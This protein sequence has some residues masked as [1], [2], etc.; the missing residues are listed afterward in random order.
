MSQTASIMTPA[1]TVSPKS[2]LSKEEAKAKREQEALEKEEKKK[3]REEEKAK[4]EE[5]KAKKEEEKKKRDEEKAKKDEERRKALEEKNKKKEEER[6]KKEED[7]KKKDEEK[8][9]KEEEKVKKEEEKKRKEEMEEEERARERARLEKNKKMWATSFGVTVEARPVPVQQPADDLMFKPYE[10]PQGAVAAPRL[11]LDSPR[12]NEQAFDQ[13]VSSSSVQIDSVLLPELRAKKRRRVHK[14]PSS[15]P[16]IPSSSSSSFHVVDLASLS[17]M[18]YL[19]F[20]ENHRPAYFGT[21]SKKSSVVRPRRPCAKD[22]SLFDYDYD[23][24]AEWEEE[25][26]G[27]SLSGSEGEEGEDAE[28]DDEEEGEKFLVP[29]GYL[30]ADEGMDSDREDR[31]LFF[32]DE[33]ASTA[34]G[35]SSSS[36]SSGK[37]RINTD[38]LADRD[39]VLKRE[40]NERP[41]VSIGVLWDPSTL[42]AS[43]LALVLPLYMQALVPVPIDPKQ[44]PVLPACED[45]PQGDA[46]PAINKKP[47]PDAVFLDIVRFLHGAQGGLSKLVETFHASHPECS[48]RQLNFRVHEFASKESRPGGKFWVVKDNVQA[49]AANLDPTVA[50]HFTNMTT[51]MN[52][53]A[54]PTPSTPSKTAPSTP[55]TA[56]SAAT[57]TTPTT[58]STPKK[59]SIMSFMAHSSAS[60]VP[61]LIPR[62]SSGLG[63]HTADPTSSPSGAKRKWEDATHPSTSSSSSASSGTPSILNFITV[64]PSVPPAPTT[65]IPTPGIPTPPPAVLP[66]PDPAATVVNPAVPATS[67][68]LAPSPVAPSLPAP[69]PMAISPPK[70]PQHPPSSSSDEEMKAAPPVDD[71]TE[72]RSS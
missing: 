24:E 55:S 15:P 52:T 61:S 20:H 14:R 30:S 58:T 1:V 2:K 66:S 56:S 54:K 18:K 17:R 35:S 7:K 10:V 45:A 62:T 44:I 49:D 37:K 68:A 67:A 50:D 43:V 13:L 28:E 29:D 48:K 32:P 8:A 22:S 71:S 41:C 26:E 23:S 34:A 40:R 46:T 39:R 38:A 36:S 65:S 3:K 69:T 12:S 16:P 11:Y 47:L 31:P 51:H 42:P 6:V 5:E 59:G 4:K 19:L 63:N 70:P 57:V 64:S 72:P 9:R 53:P 60:P 25:G 21:Y 33:M 27:E